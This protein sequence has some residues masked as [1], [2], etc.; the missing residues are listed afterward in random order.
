MMKKS[1]FKTS[2]RILC[3]ALAAAGVLPF[4]PEAYALT[5]EFQCGLEE[6]T[7]D[8]NCYDKSGALTGVSAVDDND[9]LMLITDGGTIIRTPVAGIPPRSRSAGGVIIMKM[10]EGQKIANFTKVAHAEEVTEE[11]ESSEEEQGE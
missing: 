5:G 11:A 7:H 3:A 9:D 8:E 10:G 4:S 2:Y 1:F 6:H